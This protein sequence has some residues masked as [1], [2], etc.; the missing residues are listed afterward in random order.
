MNGPEMAL[1]P[2]SQVS[3]CF[4]C[5]LGEAGPHTHT[6]TQRWST[7][8]WFIPYVCVYVRAAD[9]DQVVPARWASRGYPLLLNAPDMHGCPA[10]TCTHEGGVG[11]VRELLFDTHSERLGGFGPLLNG[12]FSSAPLRSRHVSVLPGR[13]LESMKEREKFLLLEAVCPI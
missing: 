11:R 12:T 6:H 13:G 1:L 3:A 10:G 5:C 2:P 7:Q 9:R 4:T 8:V